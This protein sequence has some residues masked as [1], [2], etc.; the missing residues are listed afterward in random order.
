MIHDKENPLQNLCHFCARKNSLESK[1]FS[2]VTTSTTSQTAGYPSSKRTQARPVCRTTKTTWK[3]PVG[4][5]H[6]LE[7]MM[8]AK[9]M[10]NIEI[11]NMKFDPTDHVY[12]DITLNEGH[13]YGDITPNEGHLY[14][15]ITPNGGHVYGDI[16]PNGG[17]VYGDITPN[18]GH[19]YGESTPNKGIS[20]L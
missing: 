1:R 20:H 12:G 19:V 5:E 11:K 10:L 2:V 16:T 13:V 7:I 6:F 9:R 18:E 14:G 15:D 8:E 17:H 4:A 3:M